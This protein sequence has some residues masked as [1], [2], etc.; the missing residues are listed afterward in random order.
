MDFSSELCLDIPKEIVKKVESYHQN[1]YQKYNLK[2]IEFVK[3]LFCLIY[4]FH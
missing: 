1:I 4:F 2:K 3:V